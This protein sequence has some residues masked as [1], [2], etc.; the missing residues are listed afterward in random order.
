MLGTNDNE[1]TYQHVRLFKKYEVIPRYTLPS[2]IFLFGVDQPPASDCAT[3]NARF[4][5]KF[6]GNRETGYPV[7]CRG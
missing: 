1:L 7:R 4:P 3:R 6:Y 2:F 5:T